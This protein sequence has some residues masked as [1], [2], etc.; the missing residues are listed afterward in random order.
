MTHYQLKVGFW[1]RLDWSVLLRCVW[2]IPGGLCVTPQACRFDVH[3]YVCAIAALFHNNYRFHHWLFSD[4]SRNDTKLSGKH[5]FK[6]SEHDKNYFWNHTDDSDISI[7]FFSRQTY[8][9]LMC[10]HKKESSR[11]WRDV[12]CFLEGWSFT[13]PTCLQPFIHCRYLK[14]QKQHSIMPLLTKC[15]N[16]DWFPR[17]LHLCNQLLPNP[18]TLKTIV[19]QKKNISCFIF[20]DLGIT[21]S[22]C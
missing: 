3:W 13:L 15:C 14:P 5:P 8:F 11:D 20:Y 19:G 12:S 9:F 17:S 10:R 2:F 4:V 16:C 7:I 18:L 22:S 6:E 21:L 1:S